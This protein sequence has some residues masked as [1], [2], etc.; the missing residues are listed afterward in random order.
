[1]YQNEEARFDI[2][3]LCLCSNGGRERQRQGLSAAHQGD[4]RGKPPDYWPTA[5]DFELR[6]AGH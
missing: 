5:E 6:L 1:V 4:K 3:W 2:R